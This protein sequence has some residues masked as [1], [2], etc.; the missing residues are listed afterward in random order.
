LWTTERWLRTTQNRLAL[1]KE[2]RSKQYQNIKQTNDVG[3]GGGIFTLSRVLAA[4]RKRRMSNFATIQARNSNNSNWN[5]P[6]KLL[7]IN[8]NK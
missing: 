7:L 1:K 3:V 8:K 5:T 2:I 4:K 6:K